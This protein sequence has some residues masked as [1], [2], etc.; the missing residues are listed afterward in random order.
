MY[1]QRFLIL[2]ALLSGTLSCA[3]YYGS[4]VS[5]NVVA[6]HPPMALLL[7]SPSPSISSMGPCLPTWTMPRESLGRAAF[8]H[9]RLWEDRIDKV[10]GHG[11]VELSPG[12]AR[13]E[14]VAWRG[15]FS[16]E[17]SSGYGFTLTPNTRVRFSADAQIDVS[18]DITNTPP[19]GA[20]R[21][22]G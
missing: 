4:G 9:R 11:L 6:I 14:A 3:R 22:R 16:P 10:P 20:R 18:H 12:A 21:R 13:A 8:Q 17:G 2:P 15:A 5:T 19:T 7:H 1:W